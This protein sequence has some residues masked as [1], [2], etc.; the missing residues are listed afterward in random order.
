[1]LKTSLAAALLA[2]GIAAAPASVLATAPADQAA[3]LGKDLTPFGAEAAGN[4]AGTIPAWTGGITGAPAGWTPGTPYADPFAADAPVTTITAANADKHADRLS[5]GQLA[6]LKAYPNWKITV[7]PTRRSFSAPQRVYDAAIRN[8]ATAR[9]VENGNGVTGASA[10]P[11]FPIPADGREAIWN[12]LLRWRAPALERVIGQ[13]APTEGGD[14]TMVN[15]HDSVFVPYGMPGATPD[16]IG[17]RVI[18]LLQR[19]TAPARLAG[20]ILLAHETLNQVAEPREVWLYNPGQ[21]RVRRA[22]STA[23]DNPG[24]ASD[25]MRTT[26]QFDIYNGAIDRYDWTLVGKK[27]MY[28][29]YNN[30]KL[31]GARDSVKPLHLNPDLLRYELHR[32]WVVEATLKGNAQHIYARRTFYIDEDS[33]QIAVVD[34]YDGRGALWRVSE[35][36][37]MNHYDVP[38]HTYAVETH[39]DLQARRYLAIGA[40]I[41]NYSYRYDVTL[42]PNDFTPDALRREGTR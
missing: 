18:Y 19:T 32:V 34:Q 39:Y 13:A 9:L 36:Y 5:P 15:F 11:P 6:M 4:A 1:M 38:V 31:A 21:R 12:H 25:G 30:Y 42:S 35:G 23:Y 27:E 29:P 37:S 16:T 20:Q 24:T 17:N 22:P 7:Y 40:I 28:I 3:R 10:A 41:P 14:Y 2:A 8:A 33:W 26:D